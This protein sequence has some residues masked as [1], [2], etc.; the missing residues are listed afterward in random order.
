MASRQVHHTRIICETDT[1][2]SSSSAE[3]TRLWSCVINANMDRDGGFWAF[4]TPAA[5][6]NERLANG[7]YKMREEFFVL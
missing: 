1:D 2:F 7:Q 3:R 4:F 5:W 6:M